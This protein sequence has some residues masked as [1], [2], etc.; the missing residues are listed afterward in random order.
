M[1]GPMLPLGEG[2]W[3]W[4]RRN[5]HRLPPYPSSDFLNLPTV[6][7]APCLPDDPEAQV[8]VALRTWETGL[9]VL[10]GVSVQKVEASPAI[11]LCIGQL[12][13]LG[14]PPAEYLLK[15]ISDFYAGVISEKLP[16]PTR[17]FVYAPGGLQRALEDLERP[18]EASH[19]LGALQSPRRAWT[20]E[21]KKAQ[22]LWHDIRRTMTLGGDAA[23]LYVEYFDAVKICRTE[24]P[25]VSQKLLRQALEGV[26]VW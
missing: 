6:P 5:G 8:E 9:R 12:A 18:G 19:W 13:A 15:R 17:G 3:E 26:Y 25:G 2:L 23:K 10:C 16:Y 1:S 7:P 21:A 24:H 14:I 4:S 11:S 22:K 20:A